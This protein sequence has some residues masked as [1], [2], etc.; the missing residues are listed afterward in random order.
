MNHIRRMTNVCN[1]WY[2][3]YQV[4]FTCVTFLHYIISFLDSLL[5]HVTK[6]LQ[7]RTSYYK[8]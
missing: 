6:F 2:E 7:V 1:V 3:L 4:Q 5:I 8:T